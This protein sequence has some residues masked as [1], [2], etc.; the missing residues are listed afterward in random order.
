MPWTKEECEVD[1]L[2]SH[3]K[4]IGSVVNVA[5][6]EVFMNGVIQHHVTTD[7]LAVRVIETPEE[8]LLV[9]SGEYLDARWYVEPVNTTAGIK[10]ATTH[11]IFDP[12]SW[13]IEEGPV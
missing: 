3:K 13:R 2:H 12:V 9:W 10:G 4:V 5:S 11:W 6:L 7:P 8:F 1:A